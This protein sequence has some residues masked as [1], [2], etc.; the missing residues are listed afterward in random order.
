VSPDL[1]TRREALLQEARDRKAVL[2]ETRAADPQ[3]VIASLESSG[4]TGVPGNWPFVM[5]LMTMNGVP[6]TEVARRAGVPERSAA[7]TVD[8]LVLGGYMERRTGPAGRPVTVATERGVAMLTVAVNAVVRPARW[9]SFPFRK[10]DI[11]ISTPPKSG[12]TWMQMIC[13]L[14]IFQTPKLS[15]PIPQLSGWVDWHHTPRDEAFARLAAYKHRRFIKT[16]APLS[17]MVVDPRVTYIVMGRNLLD[18]AVSLYHHNINMETNSADGVRPRPS[19]P[20]RDPRQMSER[21]WLIHWID[22]APVPGHPDE[23][24]SLPHLAA[25]LTDAWDRRNEPNIVL[26]HYEDLSA[27]LEGEMRRLAGRLEISVPAETWPGLVRAATFDEMRASADSLTPF[28]GLNSD[29][30][31]AFFRKGSSGYGRGLLSADEVT[32]FYERAG[33]LASR[34]LLAWLHRDMP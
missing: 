9:A 18:L 34:D 23:P 21:E 24:F 2:K 12:T 32:H 22:D 13:A 31:K 30:N 25:Q 28:P 29:G 19:Q 1:P 33:K 8:A 3:L 27:D 4:Y 16:H 7:E 5:D 17:A 10:G 26:V 15:A 14:L 20:G 6:V 11:V